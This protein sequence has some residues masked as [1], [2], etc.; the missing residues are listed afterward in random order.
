MEER[1]STTSN[2]NFVIS[3]GKSGGTPGGPLVPEAGEA[4]ML[5]SVMMTTPEP[6]EAIHA[7]RKR[8]NIAGALLGFFLLGGLGAGGFIVARKPEPSSPP[9]VAPTPAPPGVT[10]AGPGYLSL[11]TTPWTRVS[12]GDE[13]LGST[14]LFRRKLTAGRHTLTLVNEGENIRTTRA[15]EVKP[16][17]TVKV[18][19]TLK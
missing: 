15:V 6:I 12:I 8:R 2:A 11:D 17:E 1:C 4:V 13:A 19:F 10:Q 9:V 14:P 18:S 16:G 3:L 5:G 7:R